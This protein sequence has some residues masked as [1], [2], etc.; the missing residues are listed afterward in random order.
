MFTFFFFFQENARV[1]TKVAVDW[2]KKTLKSA[3]EHLKSF[4]LF[5]DNL[6]RQVHGDF[7]ESVSD[8]FGVV[9]YGLPNATDL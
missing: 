2:V 7:K 9:W 8:C 4:V 5:E 3:T 1:Y 6:I